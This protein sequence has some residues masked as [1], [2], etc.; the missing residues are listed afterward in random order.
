M[1]LERDRDARMRRTANRPLPP[2]GSRWPRRWRSARPSAWPGSRSWPWRQLA[3]GR[4]R[5]DDVRPL[6]RALHPVEVDHH[7]EHRRRRDPGRPPPVIG[8]AAATGRLGIEPWALFLIVFLW[9]FPHFLAIAW[10]Y[11]EDY[12]RGGLKMLPSVNPDGSMTGRQAMWHALELLP[13]GLIPLRPS[14]WPA[15]WYLAGAL[16]LGL[17]LP[18]SRRPVLAR[19]ERPDGP[20]AAP[21]VVPVPAAGPAPAPAEPA[22]LSRRPGPSF[23]RGASSWPIPPRSRSDSR[24]IARRWRGRR[25]RPRR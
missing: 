9:Q 10:I 17:Y 5:G 7:A 11:R 6:C 3:L 18:L 8:W 24:S 20:P 14:A 22:G 1:I 2:A 21:G 13:A 15:P 4:R 16:A 23:P 19:R 12:A 25:S